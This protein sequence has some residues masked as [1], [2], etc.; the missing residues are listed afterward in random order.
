M[1]TEQQKQIIETDKNKVVVISAPASGKTTVLVERAKFLLANGVDPSK[2]VII[3]F[4][5]A[6]A[7][8]LF[9]RLGRPENVFVGTIHS[10]A[11]Y[12]LRNYGI[13]TYEIT[14]SEEFDRLFY[15]VSVN[16]NCIK[17]VDHL[18]LDE[19]QDSNIL[20]FNF[21]FDLVKPKN[22]ML[23][24]DYR[25]SI[26][27]WMGST[28]DYIL[29]LSREK[30]V[31][32]YFLTINHRNGKEILDFAKKIIK[33]THDIDYYDFSVAGREENGK[34]IQIE[35]S[36]EDI[37]RTIRQKGNYKDWFIICRSNSQV[38]LMRESLS[39]TGVPN[40]TFKRS[41][42]DSIE[43]KQRMES[44]TVKVLTIHASK[45]LEAKN[46]VVIGA[47][48]FSR[49]LE[50]IC[51]AYVAATRAKDLLVWTLPKKRKYKRW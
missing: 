5:N 8:E 33:N 2:L 14:E 43:F 49:E 41:E 11:S 31:T 36:T 51:V 1:I 27:R 25:Q 35:L 37:A 24:G 12:L 18:L 42:L 46:V 17:E 26:Y 15:E 29:N 45:G 3:T 48:M 32:T 16:Q 19:S 9:D 50:E 6:A 34:V 47:N 10:Y 30:D 7:E 22:Y 23:V 38:D 21:L 40:T 20:H 44:D 28:P 4:T 13:G 39:A